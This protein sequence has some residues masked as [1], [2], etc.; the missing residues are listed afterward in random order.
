MTRSAPWAVLQVNLHQP[1]IVKRFKTFWNAIHYAA[2]LREDSPGVEFD[3]RF[4][5]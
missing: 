2:T 4:L 5:K 1:T 3:V